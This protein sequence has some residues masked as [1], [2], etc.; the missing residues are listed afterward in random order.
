MTPK[1]SLRQSSY[2][3]SESV[4]VHTMLTQTPD[5][6]EVMLV[7]EQETAA[8]PRPTGPSVRGNEA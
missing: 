8:S 4:N 5:D 2:Q 1:V 3:Y 7:G 6:I